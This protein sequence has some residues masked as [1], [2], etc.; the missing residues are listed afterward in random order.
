MEARKQ[1]QS[2]INRAG[3]QTRYLPSLHQP[4]TYQ[5]KVP[6][7]ID[8]SWASGLEIAF[9]GNYLPVTTLTGTVDQA[10]LHGILTRIRDLNWELVLIEQ[11]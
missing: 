3:R 4:A 10:A 6:G 5:I 9:E 11:L 7:K 2:D 8:V 1:P